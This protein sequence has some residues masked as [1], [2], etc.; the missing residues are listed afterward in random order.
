[1]RP[2]HIREG[3]LLY[4]KS[5]DLKVN[6][7]KKKTPSQKHPEKCLTKYLGTAKSTHKINL[8]RWVR[9]LSPIYRREDRHRE[10]WKSAQGLKSQT[11]NSCS[12]APEL[13]LLTMTLSGHYHKHTSVN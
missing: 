7:I 2:T 3:N 9:I 11:L 6:L 12:L 13:A 8:T 10:G 4:S 1:M 5:T